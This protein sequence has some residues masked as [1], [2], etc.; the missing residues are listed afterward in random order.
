LTTFFLPIRSTA[1]A[2]ADKAVSGDGKAVKAD[3]TAA[4]GKAAVEA[5]PD[6]M[7]EKE[8]SSEEVCLSPL[9][10]A[11]VVDAGYSLLWVDLYVGLVGWRVWCLVG[12]CG[13]PCCVCPRFMVPPTSAPVLTTAPA[14]P[15]QES[16]DE[17]ES[18]DDDS[19]ED[20]EP[21]AKKED[22]SSDD[23]SSDDED[24]KPAAKKE[25]SSSDDDSSDD[26]DEKDEKPAA[27]KADSSS[28]D[29]SSSSDDSDD[30]RTLAPSHPPLPA[31]PPPP[32]QI[33][34]LCMLSLVHAG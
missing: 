16:S 28:D 8:A 30:V 32:P 34:S 5:I 7:F 12:R 33:A 20:D 23:D 31:A 15:N 19:S 4:I 9:V 6:D 21:A 11:C 10:C 17:S 3:V 2:A 14:L 24:E 18:D 25:D 29:S 27:K 13:A 22:S 26:E 1:A